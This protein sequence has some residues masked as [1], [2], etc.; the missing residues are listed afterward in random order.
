MERNVFTIIFFKPQKLFHFM[1]LMFTR[2][3]SHMG[4]RERV[5]TPQLR[6]YPLVTLEV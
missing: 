5:E 1:K 2:S 3:T 6:P 4:E